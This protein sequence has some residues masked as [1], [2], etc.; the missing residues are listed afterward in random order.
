MAV[1]GRAVDFLEVNKPIIDKMCKV[2]HNLV[3]KKI[4][5]DLNQ[6]IRCKLEVLTFLEFDLTINSN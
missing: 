5:M 6:S 4:Y 2:E 1:K 3:S